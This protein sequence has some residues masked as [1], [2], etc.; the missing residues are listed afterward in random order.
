MIEGVTKCK[1]LAGKVLC[2]RYSGD[3][4]AHDSTRRL[5]GA[6]I[7]PMC[8]CDVELQA[9]VKPKGWMLLGLGLALVAWCTIYFTLSALQML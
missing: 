3:V 9:W 2:A 5:C 4:C 7:A 8:R 1:L 6:A